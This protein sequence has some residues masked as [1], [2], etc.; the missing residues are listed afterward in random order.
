MKRGV[1]AMLTHGNGQLSILDKKY[2]VMQLC[3]KKKRSI[4]LTKV[5]HK[6]HTCTHTKRIAI[7]ACYCT[8]TQ[9]NKQ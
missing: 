8:T 3:R 5:F 6:T 7:I 2:T 1:I 9:R 4:P